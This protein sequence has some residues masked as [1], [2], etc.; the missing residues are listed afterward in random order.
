MLASWDQDYLWQEVHGAKLASL[1][2]MD[3]ASVNQGNE[4]FQFTAPKQPKKGP[5]QTAPPSQKPPSAPGAPAILLATAVTAF[6]YVSGQY[7]KQGKLG[8]AVLGTH[9]T[10]EYKILLYASP[11]KPVAAAKIHPSFVLT[12]QPGSYATFYDDQQQNWSLMFES[13]KMAM[14]FSKEVCLAKVNAAPTLDGVVVQDLLLGEGPAVDNGDLLE[15]AYSGWLL[16][17]NAIGQMFDTNV[18][19]EKLLRLKLGAGKVIKGWEEGMLAMKKGGRRLLVIPPSLAYGAQGVPSRIPADSTLV[20]EVELRR[21]K[22]LKDGGFDRTSTG[23][24]DSSAS[25]PAPSLENVSLET[26]IQSG[27]PVASREPPLRAKSNSL[28]E[29]LA[30]P[31]STKAKL[32]SRMAKMGQPMLPFLTGPLPSQMDSSDSELEDANMLRVIEQPRGPSPPHA[33]MPA[34]P[35]MTQVPQAVAGLPV[36]SAALVPLSITPAQPQ[37]VLPASA[38]TFQ[39]YPYPQSSLVPSPMQTAGPMYSAPTVPFQAPPSDVTAFLMTEARQHNTEIRLA[40]GKVADKVEQLTAKVDEL[41]KQ[42]GAPLGLA[43]VSMETA[44]IMQNIQRIIQENER[45]KQEVFERSVR[46]EEQNTK[47]SELIKQKERYTEQINLLL[48][49]R[50]DSLKSNASQT[51]ARVLQAEQDKHALPQEGDWDQAKVAQELAAAMAQ[52]SHLQ[53]ELSAQ[54][55]KET[56]LQVQL[57]KTLREAEACQAQMS[58]LHSQVG[59]LR[60]ELERVQSLARADKQGQKQLVQRLRGLEEELGDLR[61]EKEGL[62]KTLADR[63]KKWAAERHRHD[64]ELEELRRSGQQEL[65]GLRVLLRRARSNT[66]QAASAEQLA[67]VQAEL[68]SEWQS[69]CDRLVSAAQEEHSRALAELTEQKDA[70]QEKVTQLRDKLSVRQSRHEE[71]E[72]QLQVLREKYCALQENAKAQRAQLEELQKSHTPGASQPD[73]A[74]EVKRVMNGVFQ[75]LRREIQLDESYGGT[76][77]LAIIMDTIKTVTLQM[78]TQKQDA[79]QER[80]PSDEE[81]EEKEEQTEKEVERPAE[82][83]DAQHEEE[84]TELAAADMKDMVDEEEERGPSTEC[85]TEEEESRPLP[86]EEEKKAKA[87]EQQV[88]TELAAPCHEAECPLQVP[89]ELAA[90]CHEAEGPLQVPTELAAPCHEAEGPLQ[91]PT[92]LAAPCHEVEGPL[93]VPT[94]L[95]A[96]CHE[97]EGPLQVP[98]RSSEEDQRVFRG[99]A[100]TRPP[101]PPEEEDEEPSLK[102]RPPPAPLF[103][104]DDDEEDLDWL[105]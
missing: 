46:I 87:S 81:E 100:P 43:S 49:Q 80:P 63:K 94:E 91:V 45:L 21:V 17:N 37:P 67:L 65:E 89:T 93:Q 86:E 101:P 82:K 56:E 28:S 68:E 38:H 18:G 78:L 76:A 2:G 23:S 69:K 11:Q 30:N 64:D 47:M 22:F 44:M 25:S 92:E 7:V 90:P 6:R 4:C 72:E 8:A 13:E 19:K 40:V 60:Q 55:K 104:E 53:L 70:L 59:E 3:Q 71:E 41:H 98:S 77:V 52:I 61:A 32:I 57:G 73:V 39:P 58:S 29:Q 42:G 14:D 27:V 88:P 24:R 66:D 5:V 26:G 83:G 15:V 33:Q 50:N 62:E 102:G 16:Q 84:P 75:T 99:A 36:S 96:P 31:D 12:V 1:F 35:V 34:H 95:A 103:G 20:F 74:G 54:Q 48:E 9:S 85:G 79:V 10:H 51:Q 97:A 105:G